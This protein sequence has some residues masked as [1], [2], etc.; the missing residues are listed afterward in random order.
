MP[1]KGYTQSP[2]HKKKRAKALQGEN[3]GA[4]KDGR[5]SYRRIAGAKPG[6]GTV[7]HHKDENRTNNDPSNLQ[8]LSDGKRKKGRKTTPKHEKITKRAA[9]S[10]A[11]LIALIDTYSS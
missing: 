3:N 2:E 11:Y 5:R 8:K 4:Y 6:D 9:K 1:Q 7:V 10:D